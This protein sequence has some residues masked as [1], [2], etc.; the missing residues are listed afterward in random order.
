MNRI[1]ASITLLVF[2]LTVSSA[3]KDLPM[4]VTPK[5]SWVK[6]IISD[7]GD[8]ATS[9]EASVRYILSEQQ[10]NI[11]QEKMSRFSRISMQPINENGLEHVA[12]I[13]ISFNPEFEELQLHEITVSRNNSSSSR[14]ELSEIK[15]LNEDASLEKRQ[16]N[17]RVKA[18]AILEDIRVNDVITYS[19]TIKGT[20]PILG[21][22]RFGRFYTSWGLPVERMHL[23]LVTKKD[24][25]VQFSK[26][27][28]SSVR[29]DTSDT[30]EFNWLI[31][32]SESVT[33]EDLYPSWY[34]PYS[35]I[36]FSE[37]QNWEQ[38]N[39]WAI[40]LYSNYEISNELESQIT[41]WK[42]Q[43]PTKLDQVSSAL[44]FVQDEVRY[45]GIEVGENTHLPFSPAEVFERRYGDCKDKT[46]LLIAILKK[47][48]IDAYP[49]LV[50]SYAGKIL[51]QQIPS[52]GVFDHVIVN[53]KYDSENYWLDGTISHQRGGINHIGFLDYK[54]ALVV[55]SNTNALTKIHRPNGRRSLV[56]TKEDFKLDKSGEAELWVETIYSGIRADS[57]RHSIASNGLES[58]EENFLNFYSSSYPKIESIS[59]MKATDDDSKNQITIYSKYKI[60]DWT[61]RD[62]GKRIIYVHASDI[63]EYLVE[64][65]ALIRKHPFSVLNNIDLVYQQ[66]IHTSKND[67]LD[68]SKEN[69][70][71]NT[72]YFDY[73]KTIKQTK[74]KITVKHRYS[75]KV[76]HVDAKNTADYM[77]RV[78]ELKSQLGISVVLSE[79]TA[80]KIKEQDA[81]LRSL[82]KRLMKKG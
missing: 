53:M 73:D 19:Y 28:M 16:L 52:P 79:K 55:K 77:A 5:P 29:T 9:T 49:A 13:S 22:K 18:L 61:I 62:G 2:S 56:Q 65:K 31:K 46:T 7:H 64:P 33:N 71:E 35:Y 15:V 34:N 25:Y 78:K 74:G 12:E 82:A 11:A 3:D 4:A 27:T 48:G 70:S 47:L 68:V 43:Q 76:S 14:L 80:D 44:Q 10:Y 58:L 8:E 30:T 23:R 32:N 36:D 41:H 54:N 40:D 57:L 37:Y 72:P 21:K 45:F 67:I 51:D 6:S 26:N 69:I 66:T 1:I 20:N 63:R 17:G 50:S 81:R 59:T 38:V 24:A 39:Q 60:K 42:N 75:P